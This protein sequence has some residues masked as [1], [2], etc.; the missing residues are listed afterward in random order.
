MVLL[1][2]QE[3]L[4]AWKSDSTIEGNWQATVPTP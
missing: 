3:Q 1:F 4:L 2:V